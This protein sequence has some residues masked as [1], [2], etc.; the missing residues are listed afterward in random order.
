MTDSDDFLRVE[1]HRRT[2]RYSELD[3]R[4]I[5]D[6]RGTLSGLTQKE[7]CTISAKMVKSCHQDGKIR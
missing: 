4:R 7:I 1:I 3:R 5:V 2:A 6:F